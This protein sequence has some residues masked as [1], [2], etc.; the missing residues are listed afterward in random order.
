MRIYLVATH[1]GIALGYPDSGQKR[2][3]QRDLKKRYDEIMGS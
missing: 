3:W 1:S 2:G